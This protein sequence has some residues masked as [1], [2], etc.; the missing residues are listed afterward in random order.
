MSLPNSDFICQF[1]NI[2]FKSKSNEMKPMKK[3]HNST[4]TEKSCT[5]NGEMYYLMIKEFQNRKK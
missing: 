1:C 5:Y 4:D 2:K 3:K